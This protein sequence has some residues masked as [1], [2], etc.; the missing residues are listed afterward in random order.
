ME[1]PSLLKSHPFHAV[2]RSLLEQAEWS[3]WSSS[4]HH[5]AIRYTVSYETLHYL[6]PPFLTLD[7]RILYAWEN[8]GVSVDEVMTDILRAF[9]H[10]ALRDESIEIHRNMFNT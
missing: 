9:H 1:R 4:N 8:P 6:A 2:E 10:P 3:G 5:P 7:S